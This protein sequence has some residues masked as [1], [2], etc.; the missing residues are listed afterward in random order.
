MVKGII[1]DFNGVILWDAHLHEVAWSQVAEELRGH[2]F[3]EEEIFEVV[4]GRPN[5]AVLESILERPLSDEEFK[6]HSGH[7]EEIYQALCLADPK[8]FCLS[9][10]AE[11]LFNQLVEEGIPHTI[12]TA[13]PKGNLDFFRKHLRLDRWFDPTLIVYDNGSYASKEAMFRQAAKNL[14]L[15]PKDCLVIEDSKSGI[16]AAK[17]AGIGQTIAFG[18]KST[19]ETLL[20]LDGVADAI[21]TLDELKTYDTTINS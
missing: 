13:S 14:S 5:R 16:E 19:H 17:R 15:E 8:K 11:E 3:S 10:G 18:P 21:T 2:R 9:P 7:K 4:H 6:R 20:N 1:F 12:A